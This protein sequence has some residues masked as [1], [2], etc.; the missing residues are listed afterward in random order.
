MHLILLA[1]QR[2]DQTDIKYSNKQ[3]GH[4]KQKFKGVVSL[5]QNQNPNG[6]REKSNYV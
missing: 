5:V 4:Q 6:S 1:F 2:L 3:I